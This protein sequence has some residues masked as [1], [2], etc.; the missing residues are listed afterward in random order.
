MSA[1]MSGLLAKVQLFAMKKNVYCKLRKV[2]TLF[3]KM[4]FLNCY[5]FNRERK[6]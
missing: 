1:Y 4:F 6:Y 5:F 2:M 3:A